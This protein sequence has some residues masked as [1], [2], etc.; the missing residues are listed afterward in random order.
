MTSV[1]AQKDLTGSS[2]VQNS[3]TNESQEENSQSTNVQ[4]GHNL[5]DNINK[6]T[7]KVAI[8]DTKDDN[9]D[10]QDIT[11]SDQEKSENEEVIILKNIKKEVKCNINKI[12]RRQNTGKLDTISSVSDND[13]KSSKNE[14]V[15]E[16]VF[17]SGNNLKRTRRNVR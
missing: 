12:E 4:K 3:I 15:K 11:N 13:F 14:N 9:K 8:T 17:K 1:E 16:T 6:E 7:N 5:I 2:Y 10:A